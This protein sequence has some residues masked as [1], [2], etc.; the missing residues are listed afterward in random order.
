MIFQQD[1]AP[2][3]ASTMTSELV[4]SK[5]NIVTYM[6]CSEPGPIEVNRGDTQETERT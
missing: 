4:C 5:E 3:H 1:K 2:Y 6:D